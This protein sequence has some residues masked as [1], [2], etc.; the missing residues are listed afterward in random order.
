MQNDVKSLVD[1]RF[2][3]VWAVVY[4]AREFEHHDGHRGE[5]GG[6]ESDIER[7]NMRNG[8][9]KKTPTIITIDEKSSITDSNS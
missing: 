8:S 9:F 3:K 1:S 7:S 5:E 2:R 4:I 6:L